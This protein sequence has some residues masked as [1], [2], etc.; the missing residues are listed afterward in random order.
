MNTILKLVFFSII[1]CACGGRRVTVRNVGAMGVELQLSSKTSELLYGKWLNSYE[2]QTDD[3]ILVYRPTNFPFPL[4]RGR[5][6][7]EFLKDGQFIEHGFGPTDR[8]TTFEG[9]WIYGIETQTLEITFHK[10]EA[11]PMPVTVKSRK[12]YVL[13]I[14]SLENGLLKVKRAEMP[15]RESENVKKE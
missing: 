8:P 14:I 15:E 7:I 2:E 10:L 5:K 4:S 9:E 12:G 11:T 1:I 13:K 3:D 6:G